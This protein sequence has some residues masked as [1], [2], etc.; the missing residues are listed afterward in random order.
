MKKWN[1]MQDNKF[2]RSFGGGKIVGIRQLKEIEEENSPT[3]I[4]VH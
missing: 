1:V 3:V 4:M 2:L